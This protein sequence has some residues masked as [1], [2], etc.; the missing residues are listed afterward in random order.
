MAKIW[1]LKLKET[2][3]VENQHNKKYQFW[4]AVTATA[5]ALSTFSLH[6]ALTLEGM[7][8]GRSGAEWLLFAREKIWR[9]MNSISETLEHQEVDSRNLSLSI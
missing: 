4:D 1:E 7:N 5:V 3:D 6:R 8:T 2:F 9:Q